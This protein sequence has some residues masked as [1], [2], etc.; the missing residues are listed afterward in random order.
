MPTWRTYENGKRTCSSHAVV[1]YEY[2]HYLALPPYLASLVV[3]VVVMVVFQCSLWGENVARNGIGLCWD[4]D[5]HPVCAMA[6]GLAF[7][8]RQAQNFGSIGEEGKDCGR[9]GQ[10]R[11][12]WS[13]VLHGKSWRC[14]RSG[15][16][17]G[18][19]MEMVNEGR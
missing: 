17:G 7:V 10:Q 14:L 13:D 2:A 12:E 9:F 15:G 11:G 16:Q 1:P 4:A 8:V 3:M 19:G 5:A 18:L 6:Y